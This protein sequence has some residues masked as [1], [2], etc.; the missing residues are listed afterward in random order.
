MVR[1]S[2]FE[3]RKGGQFIFEDDDLMEVQ[4]LEHDAESMM[5]LLENRVSKSLLFMLNQQLLGFSS[6]MQQELAMDMVD[7]VCDDVMRMTGS[8][9]AD[10]VLETCYAWIEDEKFAIERVQSQACLNC[11]ERKQT[12]Y[13]NIKGGVA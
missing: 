10:Y 4:Y 11:A 5:N 9:S 7:Y 12:R 6:Q 1:Q 3:K 13:D 8:P 2:I